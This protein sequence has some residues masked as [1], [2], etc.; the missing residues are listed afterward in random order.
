MNSEPDALERE[1]ESLRP[2]GV[3]HEL[4][5]SIADRIGDA[6]SPEPRGWSIRRWLLA[7]SVSAAGLAAAVL[8]FLP[9]AMIVRSWLTPPHPGP[10]QRVNAEQPTIPAVSPSDVPNA[11]TLQFYHRALFESPETLDAVL[12]QHASRYGGATDSTASVYSLLVKETH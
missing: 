1:L 4:R 6:A 5:R 12:A 8:L 3:S 9:T 7:G 11:P 2:T 10:R